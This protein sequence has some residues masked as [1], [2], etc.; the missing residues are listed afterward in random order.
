MKSQEEMELGSETQVSRTAETPLGATAYVYVEN[1]GGLRQVHVTIFQEGNVY[2]SQ[3]QVGISPPEF[4]YTASAALTTT[5]VLNAYHTVPQGTE[6]YSKICTI[7]VDDKDGKRKTTVIYE[8][9]R[10]GK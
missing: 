4:V 9:P 2:E 7:H 3:E 1:A 10:D 5:A 6:S 8:S